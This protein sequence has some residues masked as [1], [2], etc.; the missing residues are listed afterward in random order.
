MRRAGRVTVELQTPRTEVE[1][2]ISDF[3]EVTR[4]VGEPLQDGWNRFTVFA[5]PKT[6][7][8]VKIGNL[9]AEKKW[10]LR[11]L[12]RRIGTLEEVFIELTRKD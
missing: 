12:G 1:E 5:A 6:D 11:S 9:A 7:T 8:R 2:I 4:V 10:P 3:E